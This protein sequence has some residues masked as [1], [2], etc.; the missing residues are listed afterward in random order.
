MD[1]SKNQD[2][3]LVT[4]EAS[5]PKRR[6]AVVGAGMTGLCALRHF[7]EDPAY[8]LTAFER[9]STVGGIWNYPDG[10]EDQPDE[11]GLHPYYCRTYRGLR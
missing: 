1:V 2:D 5:S 6:V 8:E 3:F 11:T 10:C 7:S 9:S 4:A